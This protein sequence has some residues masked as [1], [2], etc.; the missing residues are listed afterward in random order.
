MA[1]LIPL[2]DPDGPGFDIGNGLYIGRKETCQIRISGPTVS[3]VQCEVR[4]VAQL[5]AFQVID[6]SSNGTF[7]NGQLMEKDQVAQLR[8]G[9]V[10]QL[11]RRWLQSPGLQ[12]RF[13]ATKPMIAATGM[14]E[15]CPADADA[16]CKADAAHVMDAASEPQRE[17]AC[18]LVAR[19]QRSF[20]E[21]RSRAA[22]LSHQL[23]AL[24]EDLSVSKPPPSEANAANTTF[25][26]GPLTEEFRRA[27]ERQRDEAKFRAE[28]AADD[29]EVAA[30]DRQE[31]EEQIHKALQQ[32]AE[33]RGVLGAQGEM[34]SECKDQQRKLQ[35]EMQALIC[36][37]QNIRQDT[38][39]F[40][41]NTAAAL[42]VRSRV[43]QL[44]TEQISGTEKL[45]LH[46]ESSVSEIQSDSTILARSIPKDRSST[47][48]E[49]QVRAKRPR[50]T[51]KSCEVPP[52]SKRSLEAGDI[53]TMEIL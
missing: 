18:E 14:A 19:L 9:D 12:F 17:V 52:T 33:L 25:D 45:R 8:H 40:R 36:S 24:Q 6:R 26:V 53:P 32:H 50:P 13:D 31:L 30:K 27:Q 29:A 46:L 15:G 4:W 20:E 39:R 10:V 23:A 42:A 51:A 44:V 11:T 5:E 1:R 38:A 28:E 21:V 16:P 37:R 3:A 43:Q 47:L 41:E 7:L 2:T 48:T 22:S 49:G 34:V 35:H